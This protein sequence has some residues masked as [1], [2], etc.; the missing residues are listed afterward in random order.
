MKIKSLLLIVGLLSY[1]NN[2][3]A[4]IGG[5]LGNLKDKAKDKVSNTGNSGNNVTLTAYDKHMKEGNTAEE[6]KDYITAYKEYKLA[7]KEKTNDYMA[8]S[9][10]SRVEAEAENQYQVKYNELLG[11]GNCSEIKTLLSDQMETID[12]SP[13]EKEK[14]GDKITSCESDV[15]QQKMAGENATKKP[16]QDALVEEATS[17]IESGAYSKAKIKLQEAYNACPSCEDAPEILA[18][19][20]SMDQI[21]GMEDMKYKCETIPTDNGLSGSVHESN[22]GKIVFAKTEIVKSAENPSAFTNSFT[23]SDNI[24]SRV[25]LSHSIGYECAN[26]GICFGDPYHLTTYRY[27]V[28]DGTYDFSKSYFDDGNMTFNGADEDQINKWTTWQPALSPASKDG[29]GTDGLQF[30]YSMLEFLPAGKHK[31]KLEIVIDI[32]EDQEPAGSRTEQNCKKYTTKFG[33]EKVLASGEFTLEVKEADK[34][35]IK[36][37]TGALSKAE[38]DKKN[39]AAFNSTME[40]SGVWLINKC[41]NPVKVKVAGNYTTVS[42]NSSARLTLKAGDSIE[43]SSGTLIRYFTSDPPS[44]QRTDVIICN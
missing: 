21:T 15:N 44:G 20:Q 18:V 5:K 30:F 43:S 27:T 12:M 34:V 39:Q 7:L 42:G 22:M 13:T 1:V 40:N 31:I 2:T 29:Y 37:K 3:N 28:D 32:P 9:A 24:Y 33:P 14:L 25:Y 6:K 16:K 41:S 36:N 35:K 8:T 26:M 11:Q 19:M 10:K 4:Q 38:L 23:T 17:L